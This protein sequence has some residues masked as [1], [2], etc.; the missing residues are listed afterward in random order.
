LWQV[1]CNGFVPA[2][3]AALCASAGGLKDLPLGEHSRLYTAAAG[4]FFG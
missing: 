1:F 2:V 4:A 3:L